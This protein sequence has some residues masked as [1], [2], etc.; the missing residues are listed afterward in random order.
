MYLE[1]RFGHMFN[2]SVIIFLANSCQQETRF[3]YKEPCC[4]TMP[5]V[6]RPIYLILTF[7]NRNTLSSDNILVTICL[8]PY[9][10]PLFQNLCR[11]YQCY[12]LAILISSCQ[13]FCYLKV[14][15]VLS[16]RAFFLWGKNHLSGF[17]LW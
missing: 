14:K 16:N 5:P 13:I 11:E 1:Q 10:Y 4:F 3:Y 6:I 8:V 15:T 12:F 2:H 17:G 9:F 7:R